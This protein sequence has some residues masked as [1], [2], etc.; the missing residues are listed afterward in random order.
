MERHGD[1][2]VVVVVGGGIVGCAIALGLADRGVRPVLVDGD[3]PGQA[4]STLSFASISALGR[5]PVA[6]YE[7]ACAGM[8]S[9]SRWAA[10]LGD[11]GFRRGGE[12]RWAA[13]P[14]E[15]GALVELVARAQRW[16]YP[17]MQVD[18]AKLREL[19]PAAEPGPVLAA[20]HA[21]R[22][23]QVEPGRVVAA[24]REQLEAAGAMLLL[25]RR[26][27]LRVDD[28]GVR[29]DVGEE[30]L[31]PATTVL[32]AGAESV[33]VAAS[34]G[35]DVPLAA[36]PG[37]LVV[38]TP[39]PPLTEAVVYL[40][41]GPGPPVH[42]RQRPD[43]SVLV[44]ERS[45]E[46]VAADLSAGHARTLLAQAARFFPGLGGAAVART[47]VGWRAM[48]AD[49][50]PIVGP[51]PGLESLYL[52]VSPSGVTVAPALGR[53]VAEEIVDGTPDGLLGA[54][55]PGRF[56]DRAARVMLDV[57]SAFQHRPDRPS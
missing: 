26:A 10:R 8:A 46:T 7:L 16:G 24:C 53:L 34:V 44:G 32:A 39:L 22:V 35:L 27:R 14:D 33:E 57:E 6:A 47:V 19:L 2:P 20:C 13:S 50:L 49:R 31:R 38:T 15:A 56:A 40:P 29:V 18:E 9:W 41:G 30:V 36:S 48:P 45:Q 25:G 37:L 11:V 28:D 21:P 43:G 55:R 3:R 42:L 12:V 52:A 23:A 5:D 17:V 1:G 54:F 51:V 4:A